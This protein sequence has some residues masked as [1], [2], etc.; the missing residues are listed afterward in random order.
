MGIVVD[1]YG[2]EGTDLT[3]LPFT[4]QSVYVPTITQDYELLVAA[5]RIRS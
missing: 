5:K 2:E 1:P 3:K 4:S